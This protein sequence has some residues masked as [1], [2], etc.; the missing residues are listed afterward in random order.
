MGQDVAD[1]DHI[2]IG[3]QPNSRLRTKSL[4]KESLLAIVEVN[5]G[6][7]AFGR[8]FDFQGVVAT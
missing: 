1:E 3:I 5:D 2:E 8:L 4:R 7:F 6:K